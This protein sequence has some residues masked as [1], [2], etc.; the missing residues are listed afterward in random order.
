MAWTDFGDTTFNFPIPHL[1][2]TEFSA[3][4]S[5]RWP[6]EVCFIVTI[7]APVCKEVSAARRGR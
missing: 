7:T 6:P 4:S 3:V 1:G 2:G 5:T